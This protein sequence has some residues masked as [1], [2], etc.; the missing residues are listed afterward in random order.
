MLLL[1]WEELLASS[2]WRR[3]DLGMLLLELGHPEGTGWGSCPNS[4]RNDTINDSVTQD[5]KFCLN[6]NTDGTLTLDRS[7]AYYYQVQTQIFV[8]GVEYADFVV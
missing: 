5:K 4:H 7:H 8:C 1:G 2:H 6:E 3:L